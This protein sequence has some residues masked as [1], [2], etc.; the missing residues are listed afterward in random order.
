MYYAVTLRGANVCT[1]LVA[2]FKDQIHT[3]ILQQLAYVA[4]LDLLHDQIRALLL[5]PLQFE[6]EV[7]N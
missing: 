3:F 4:K 1:Y 6:I 7:S 5:G 2:G